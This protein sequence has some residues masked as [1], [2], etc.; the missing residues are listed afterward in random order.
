MIL[1]YEN[2]VALLLKPY[3]DHY[4]YE[5]SDQFCGDETYI[6]VNGRRHYLFSFFDTVKKIILS[7]PVSANRYTMSAIRSIDEILLKMKQIPEN[8]TFDVDENPIYLQGIPTMPA[9]WTK[10]IELA[11]QWMIEQRVV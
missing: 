5:L 10:L 4:P 11:Q 8:I 2:S 6:R 7:Y 9:R 3:V 1:N